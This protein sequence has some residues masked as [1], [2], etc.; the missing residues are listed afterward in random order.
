VSKV[1]EIE[2]KSNFNLF[3]CY[4]HSL[5]KHQGAHANRSFRLS[6]FSHP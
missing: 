6:C 2:I 3:C 5:L 4:D 1:D